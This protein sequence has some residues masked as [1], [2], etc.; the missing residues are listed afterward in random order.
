MYIHTVVRYR[1]LGVSFFGLSIRQTIL[2]GA[3]RIFNAD[4][5]ARTVDHTHNPPSFFQ[6]CSA[7]L[8]RGLDYNIKINLTC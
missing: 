1:G 5:S 3:M 7:I 6:G 2:G 4:Q 8:I